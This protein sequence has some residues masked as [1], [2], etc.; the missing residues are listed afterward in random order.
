MRLGAE[1]DGQSSGTRHDVTER[2]PNCIGPI[3]IAIAIRTIVV[4]MMAA[5]QKTILGKYFRGVVRWCAGD[6]M[7]G[8]AIGCVCRGDGMPLEDMLWDRTYVIA[9]WALELCFFH[10]YPLGEPE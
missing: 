2:R 6:S 10:I 7:D 1:Q 4:A 8:G 3:A 9:G 5:T